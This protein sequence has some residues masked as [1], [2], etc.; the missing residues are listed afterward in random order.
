M[1]RFIGQT[2]YL[3]KNGKDILNGESTGFLACLDETFY[4]KDKIY[5]S[6]NK[7]EAIGKLIVENGGKLNIERVVQLSKKEIETLENIAQYHIIE[8]KY[9]GGAV[10]L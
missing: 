9:Q 3:I 7:F 4:D 2:I 6:E 1:G 8:E 10:S 5:H